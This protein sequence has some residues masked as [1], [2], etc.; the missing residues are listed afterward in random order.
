MSHEVRVRSSVDIGA[1]IRQRR[2]EVGISSLV[3]F[4]SMT[5]HSVRFLSEVER[6]KK[7]ASIESVLSILNELG[8]DLMALPR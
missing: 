5:G 8:I 7:G 2:R 4:S 6:G 3:E 1:L